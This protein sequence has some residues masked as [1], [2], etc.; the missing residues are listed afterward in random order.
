M[1]LS[2][3]SGGFHDIVAKPKGEIKEGAYSE[4]YGIG[5]SVD[6]SGRICHKIPAFLRSCALY[7]KVFSMRL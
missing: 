1:F 4:Q 5:F 3:P 7:G 6:N 2:Q